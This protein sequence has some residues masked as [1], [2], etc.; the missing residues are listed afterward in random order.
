MNSGDGNAYARHV[1]EAVA[2]RS[3]GK[4]VAFL[5]ARTQDVAAAEDALLEASAAG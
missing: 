2:G 5:A 4:L 1:A 3:Y